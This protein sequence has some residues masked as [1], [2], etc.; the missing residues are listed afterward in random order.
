MKFEKNLLSII[1]SSRQKRLSRYRKK[2]CNK[3][4]PPLIYSNYT[5]IKIENLKSTESIYS[6]LLWALNQKLKKVRE[7][8]KIKELDS[9]QLDQ[10]K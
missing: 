1:D 10:S 9:I 6:K 5:K 7:L 3:S 4:T 8:I 2:K